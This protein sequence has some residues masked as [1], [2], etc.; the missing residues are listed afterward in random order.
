MYYYLTKLHPSRKPVWQREK[1]KK[2][3]SEELEDFVTD[4]NQDDKDRL[5]VSQILAY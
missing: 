4:K 5:V 3:E 1:G 2:T